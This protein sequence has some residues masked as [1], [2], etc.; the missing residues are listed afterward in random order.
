MVSH[1]TARGIQVS[2]ISNGSFFTRDRV[3]R[4]LGCGIGS[5]LVSLESPDAGEFQRIRGGKFEKVVDGIRLLLEERRR[6]GRDRP[7]VGFAVTVLKDT[8][9][10][11]LEIVSL[12][13]ELG[14]DGGIVV[15]M[16]NPMPGYARHYPEATAAQVLP[17]L[18]QALAWSRWDRIRARRPGEAEELAGRGH[19]FSELM[20]PGPDT[21]EAECPWLASALYVDRHGI[22]GACPYRHGASQPVL[23]HLEDDGVQAVLAARAV[24]HDTLREG[25]IPEGCG[26]CRIAERVTRRAAAG[27]GA[28]R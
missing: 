14:L 18:A 26:G 13:D 22:A 4:L 5:I 3:T 6:A 8:Q 19:F 9:R 21:K 1:A 16:L 23:G 25:K 12:Y 10:R 7:R 27:A 2:T 11:L 28:A 15:Q 17:P 20:E 24:L